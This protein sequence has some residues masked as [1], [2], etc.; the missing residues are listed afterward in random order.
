MSKLQEPAVDT[1]DEVSRLISLLHDTTRQIEELTAGQVDSVAD[2]QGRIFLLHHAQVQLREHEAIRQ[3]SVLNALPAH[4]ALIDELGVIVSVND[5]WRQFG[6]T[7]GL[8]TPASA[9]GAN[10][11]KVCDSAHGDIEADARAVAA[12]IRSVLGGQAKSFSREYSCHS[13]TQ[14]RW[15]LMRVSPVTAGM[16][17]GAVIMHLDISAEKRI[18]Q[19]LLISESRFRQLAENIRDMFFLRDADSKRM[20]YVSP[21][22]ETIWCR[23]VESL[24]ADPHSW[25]DSIHP[26]DRAD[27]QEKSRQG[28]LSGEFNLHYRIVRPDG[29]VRWIESKGTPVRNERGQIV[30]IAGIASDFTV[31]K[32]AQEALQNSVNEQKLLAQEL[33]AERSRLLDA[34]RVAMVGSWETNMVDATVRWSEEIHRIF[35]TDPHTLNPTHQGFLL[36]VHPADRAAVEEAFAASFKQKESCS[37]EHRLLLPDGR[38]KFVEERWQP[39]FDQAGQPARAV[40]TCQDI[41]LRMQSAI[42][43][44]TSEKEFRT[45]AES[46]PQ[47]VWIAG[48][49]GGNTYFNQHWMDYTGLSLE[50][51]LGEGWIKPLHPEDRQRAWNTWTLAI[52]SSGLYS[53]ECRLRRLDGIYRWWLLR[54]SPQKHIDGSIIKWFGTCTD[55]HDLKTA[56]QDIL[57]SNIELRA[58]E[59]GVKRLNRVYAVLSGI[60]GLI[61]RVRDRETLFRD[62]CQLVVDQGGFRMALIALVDVDTNK[63]NLVASAGKDA[64]LVTTIKRV[65]ASDEMAPTTII[66]RVIAEKKAFVSNDSQNDPQVIFGGVYSAAGVRSIGVLP[67]MV[68]GQA[69]GVL[70]LYAGDAD[71]FHAGEM[72]LLSELAAD[73]AFAIDFIDKRE[74]LDYMAYFD[75]LTG[76]A[77]RNLFHERLEKGLADAGEKNQALSLVLLDIER[78][79]IINDTYGRNA[80]DTLLRDIAG[81]MSR[82]G[83]NI[84]RL[85]RIDADH[86]AVMVPDLGTV[87]ELVQIVEQRIREVFNPSFQVANADLRISAKFGIARFPGDGTSAEVLF[88]NAEVALKNA[89]TNG[90][91]YLF[92]ATGMNERVAEKLSLENQLRRAIESEEFVL[93][94]QPKVNLATGKLMS[95]EA[96]I[97]WNDPQTGLVPPGRFIPILEETGLIFEVGRWA[98]RKAIEDYLRWRGAGLPA[99][100][101]AVN[102]S[103]LQLRHRD[104]MAEIEQVLSIDA[105]AAAGLELEITESLIMEDVKHSI[106]S[107]QTIRAMGVTVAID[108]F[109]TGFSSLSYLAR[110]PVDT[111]KIDR[112]FVI[113]MTVGPQG[114]ALVSTIINLAHSLKLKVVAEG[115]ETEEQSRLLRLLGCDE[116]QGF[117]FSRPVPADVFE[118]KFLKKP[119]A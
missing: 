106:S 70:A 110:L 87:E 68:S 45:L 35:E 34:Q 78:F 73:V 103:P 14:D 51:S 100:R 71:F 84:E 115:V 69:V 23:S 28:L 114:L 52:S 62:A 46:M 97:R 90:N 118:E 30:R 6:A 57:H 93:H 58:S 64:E 11:L 89:K 10:Y 111:L 12:G 80:G 116:M 113:D 77:N 9:V 50:E 13:P 16:S 101:I 59:I 63:T 42:A 99:V 24:Y 76:L 60:N 25:I 40:G 108:D 72:H 21:A 104:F 95:A 8:L 65:L 66:A 20:L 67:L 98:M 109:G 33:E 117:L 79:K 37:I 105:N 18:E 107:L 75:A 7:N 91:R 44:Q 85:A 94:Y 32:Q 119:D 61:V 4:I 112:S 38:I 48:A 96:L 43:L 41:T 53:I 3:A 39:Y 83:V 26:E 36:F 86:F 47:I 55:I 2:S 82:Y 17:T 49:D 102:V 19:N 5:A 29:T 81:R 31:E 56:E 22:Y 74:R 27:V 1:T 15:F 88:R 92:Y 54:G